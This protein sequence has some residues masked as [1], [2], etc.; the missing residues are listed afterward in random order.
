MKPYS[1]DETLFPGWNLIPSVKPSCMKPYSRDETLFPGWNLHAW[2]LIPG[3]KPSYNMPSDKLAAPWT[4]KNTVLFFSAR[5]SVGLFYLRQG[6]LGKGI[7]C[8]AM[9]SCKTRKSRFYCVATRF[10]RNLL[11]R[12]IFMWAL[13][14]RSS[15]R[16]K[17]VG[18]LR[19]PKGFQRFPVVPQLPSVFFFLLH[20]AAALPERV[21][22]SYISDVFEDF[23]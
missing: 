23:C 2:N 9:R 5:R 15:A 11:N 21:V 20:R 1:R 12:K 19:F 14:A 4:T 6:P 17:I 13:G 7:H 10:W 3:N 16:R 8:S 22:F 18:C